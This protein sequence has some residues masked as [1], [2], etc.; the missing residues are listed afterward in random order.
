MVQSSAWKSKKKGA[1]ASLIRLVRS[2]DA[3]IMKFCTS[4]TNVNLM[5]VAIV[6][7]HLEKYASLLDDTTPLSHLSGEW[8]AGCYDETAEF[9]LA[10]SIASIQANQTIPIRENLEDINMSKLKFQRSRSRAWNAND[11]T[12]RN[13][14][15]VLLRRVL[16]GNMKSSSKMPLDGYIPAEMHDIVMFLHGKLNLEKIGE[17]ILPLSFI[18]MAPGIDYPWK[19]K[20]IGDYIPLPEAYLLLKLIY[21]PYPGY[22]IPHDTSILNLLQAGRASVAYERGVYVLRSHGLLPKTSLK[23]YRIGFKSMPETVSRH[24][25]ASLLFPVSDTD[26]KFMVKS[27]I[28]EPSIR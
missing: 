19:N 3:Q 28:V 5:Q 9:R 25:M 8:L 15:R 2:L 11:T 27:V 16:E 14:E 12:L 20:R 22:D 10:A 26:R 18:N 6:M 13:M 4:P 7:G 23:A 21:P 24:V 17:L 1:P